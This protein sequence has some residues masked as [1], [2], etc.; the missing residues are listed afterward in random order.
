MQITI[1]FQ[2]H[3]LAILWKHRPCLVPIMF[4]MISLL[5]TCHC[6]EMDT[7]ITGNLS[8]F[9]SI[10][11]LVDKHLV[12]TKGGSAR[13]NLET[14]NEDVLAEMDKRL[15]VSRRVE[16]TNLSSLFGPE[17]AIR[18]CLESAKQ[19]S[20]KP[21][22]VYYQSEL[23]RNAANIENALRDILCSINGQA[24]HFG[25]DL[26]QVT[27]HSTGVCCHICSQCPRVNCVNM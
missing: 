7:S 19:Y 16:N 11:D 27:Q 21:E 15:V 22:S 25:P 12:Y 1:L 14:V 17:R 24:T 2:M 20:R 26:L 10:Y 18:N 5:L 9:T 23:I 8:S 3:F 6:M 4:I 13:R